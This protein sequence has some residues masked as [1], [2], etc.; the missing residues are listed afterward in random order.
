MGGKTC[1]CVSSFF[2][3][4]YYFTYYLPRRRHPPQLTSVINQR[5]VVAPADSASRNNQ[6][7]TE[8]LKI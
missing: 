3:S 1:F 4:F 5:F 7:K 8:K 6:L 2:C